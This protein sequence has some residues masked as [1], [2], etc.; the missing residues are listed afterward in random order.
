MYLCIQLLLF[1]NLSD[2][3]EHAVQVCTQLSHSVLNTVVGLEGAVEVGKVGHHVQLLHQ[4][5]HRLLKLA[6]I[7]LLVLSKSPNDLS[8]GKLDDR[9]SHL[10]TVLYPSCLVLAPSACNNCNM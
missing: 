5:A 8:R 6:S 9:Q 1:E 4:G 3:V 2:L 10:K 7:Q